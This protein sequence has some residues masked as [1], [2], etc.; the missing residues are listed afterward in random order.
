MDP[1]TRITAAE[2]SNHPWVSGVSVTPNN[3]LQSPNMLGGRQK[4]A[5]SSPITPHTQ[6]QTMH[7]K[8]VEANNECAIAN[9]KAGNNKSNK[10]CMGGG[11]RIS[12]YLLFN[13]VLGYI[14]CFCPL[15]NCFVLLL[16]IAEGIY[17]EEERCR[18]WS[19]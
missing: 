6:M 5:A 18:L 11:G 4:R 14:Q 8:L 2:A 7:N 15:V 19:S 17:I 1:K 10:V 3:Y 13:D 16:V 12:I 9:A